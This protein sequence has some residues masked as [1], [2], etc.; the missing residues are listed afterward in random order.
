MMKLNGNTIYLTQGDTLDLQ[1][2]ILDQDGEPYSPSPEDSIRFAL[3]K[4]YADDEPLILKE[5]PSETLRLRLESEQTKL[6]P[7][8]KTPYVY[9]IEI[10][11]SDGTVDT[12]IDR[13]KLY[14]T[15]EV[16]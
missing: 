7:V 9:D 15:E 13:Q 11:L 8:S 1:V 3:K 5:I 16:Y 6:L 4:N 14:I 10:T 2:N 12:F